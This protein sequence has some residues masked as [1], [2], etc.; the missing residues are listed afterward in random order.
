ME[1]RRGK[2]SIEE[3]QYA[4]KIIEGRLLIEKGIND[5]V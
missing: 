5:S 3:E 2:W 1:N 4:E